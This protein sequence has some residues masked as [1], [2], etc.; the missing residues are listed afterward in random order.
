MNQRS[1]IEQA[2]S[3]QSLNIQSNTKTTLFFTVLVLAL[4][5]AGLYILSRYYYPLFHSI[6]DMATVFIATGVFMVVWTRRRLLDNHY[7]LFVG[8]AFL[9]FGL[10]DFLHLLGNKNMGVFP[11]YGNLGPTLYIASRYILGISMVIAPL[12]IRRKINTSLT[13]AVYSMVTVLLILSIFYWQNFPVT[14]IEGV[15]LTRFKV[16]SDYIVCFIL[17]GAIGLLWVNRRAFDPKVLR[18]IVYS[19]LFSIATG[20]AFTTYTD[21]F[22]VTNA[23]GHFF[24]IA[25]FYLVYNAFINTVLIKP[26]D[27]LY[28]NLQQSKEEVTKLNTELEKV[29]LDLKQDITERKKVEEN[30]EKT[31]FVLSEGQRIA[32]VGTFEYIAE[33]QTTVWSDE[34]CRIYGL[35]A[36]TPSP[37]YDVML[38]NFIHRDDAALLHETFTK[39]MQSG[40]IYELEHRVIRPDGSVRVVY[41]LAR[42]Y[43]DSKGNLLRYIGTTLDITESKKAEEALRESEERFKTIATSTPDHIIVQDSDLRYIFVVNPQLGMTEKDMLGKT[44]YDILT[45]DDADKL[46]ELKRQVIETGKSVYIETPASNRKGEMDYFSGSYIPRFNAKGKVSG[47]IGYF[48]NITARKKAEAA[49]RESEAKANALIKYAPTGIYEIDFRT[50]RFL[51]VNDAMTTLSGY[52]REE[53]F[54]MGPG[55]LLDDES[56]KIFTERARRQLAGEKVDP[57]IE[58]KVKK[59]DGSF[60]FVNLNVAFS[61]VNPSTVFVIGHD[62]TE[63]KK[64]EDQIRESEERFRALSETSPIGVGVSSADG[65]LLYANRSYELILGYNPT[66]LT[67]KKASDLY[68]D[69]ADRQSWVSSMQNGGVVRNVETRLKRKDGTP[70]WVSINVSP[71][72]YGSMQA[73]MGTIQDITE[74]KEAEEALKRYAADLEISNKEL[75]SFSYSVSHDLR[76]PLRGIDGFSNA[77]LEDYEDQLDEQ[78]KD[79]LK[80]IRSSSQLMS[81]LIDGL[82]K[83]SRT[84]RAEMCPEK[85]NLSGIVRSISED[86]KQSQLD[87]NAEFII[88]QEIIAYGDRSLLDAVLRN[89]LENAWKF[90]AK[91][92]ETRI[93]FGVV[94]QDGKPVYYV[95]DNGIGFDIRYYDKLFKVF[96]RLHNQNDYPGTGIGLA[97]VQRIVRRHGGQIWADSETGKGA[98]FYFT[99]NISN[100]EVV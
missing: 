67:G 64:A 20:L 40:S 52:N 34:E 42:P 8:I 22:G 74:R 5:I 76:A 70:I 68:W 35:A 94:Q 39:A 7:Y 82:L 48:E 6:I 9:F 23:I 30:L 57:T 46:T 50:G 12:F 45:K 21:P 14:Y 62:V 25:S 33:T 90:T 49:L 97:N 85:V 96:S 83:L 98:T 11:G 43:F 41:D 65:V 87:R 84:A 54:A 13:L 47:L 59:K 38:A 91:C 32:H 86:L 89:L 17:M 100:P 19:L 28:R 95:K 63:R 24:Q 56:N 55:A 3:D 44:D 36:G 31:R 77:L 18:L 92:S 69:P 75:E 16:I 4:A 15:G 1:D 93:E 80:R 79:Y 10:L 71:V 51:N 88:S 60:I 58:Y 99:L 27:I 72:F 2:K 29:N 61:K 81:Q 78:G 53:L 26:Q 37:A 73:V 66:E